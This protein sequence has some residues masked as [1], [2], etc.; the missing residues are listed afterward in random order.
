LEIDVAFMT[1]QR[2][3][4]IALLA[5]AVLVTLCYFFVDRPFA[6]FI[7]DQ[8]LNRFEALKWLT[9]H[10]AGPGKP[11]S[12]RPRSRRRAG[13]GPA[14]HLERTLFCALV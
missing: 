12:H 14:G 10:A 4:T 9:Y 11:R 3:T 7:H 5:C 2:R 6:Y 1:L 13:V 8:H